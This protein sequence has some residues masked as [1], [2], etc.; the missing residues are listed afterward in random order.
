VSLSLG[1]ACSSFG[2]YVTC[3][4]VLFCGCSGCK[5]LTGKTRDASVTCNMLTGTLNP[6]L[7]HSHH[8]QPNRQLFITAPTLQPEERSIETK[9][10][11]HKA[12][13]NHAMIGDLYIRIL[14]S[15]SGTESF[16]VLSATRPSNVVHNSWRYIHADTWIDEQ[17][18]PIL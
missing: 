14:D 13:P 16:P 3:L 5:W 4:L 2:F 1:P 7:S 8:H 15:G 12:T 10:R 18:W 9:P 6:S 17:T 11:Q